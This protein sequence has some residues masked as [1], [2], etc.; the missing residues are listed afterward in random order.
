MKTLHSLVKR[1]LV[2]AGTALTCV[3]ALL[4]NVA[5]AQSTPTIFQTTL[6]EANQLTPEINTEE[7]RAILASGSEPVFDVRSALE[8]A[9][10]HIPGAINIPEKEVANI[11]AL[12]PDPNAPMILSC[13]G[14]FCGKSKRT[15]EQ[16]VSAGYTHVRRYQ[17]G[18]P[19]WRALGNTVQTDL[20]GFEYMLRKDHTTIFVDARSALEFQSGT[21]HCAVNIQAGEATAAND[22]GRLP[23]WDKGSRVVVFANSPAEAQKVAAEIAKKAYWN[24]SYFGGSVLDLR[25]AHLIDD[26]EDESEWRCPGPK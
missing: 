1:R 16:L 9:I 7:L 25:R 22:D 18:M 17:L 21:L 2:V 14:P 20:A 23:N 26:E 19:V 10:A 13:N 12:Y 15:S 6:Q 11:I 4:M 24:S 5:Q 8:F 3:A